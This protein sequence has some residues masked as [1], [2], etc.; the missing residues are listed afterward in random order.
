MFSPPGREALPRSEMADNPP[1]TMLFSLPPQSPPPATPARPSILPV[2]NIESAPADEADE[3]PAVTA[4]ATPVKTSITPPIEAQK[5]KA[6]SEQSEKPRAAPSNT[7]PSLKNMHYHK[8]ELLGEI[9]PR[10]PLTARRQEQ[11]GLIKLKAW[12]KSSG[13]VERVEVLISSGYPVLDMAASKAVK[14]ARF[15]PA[16]MYSN[17]VEG[18]VIISISFQLDQ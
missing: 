8:P 11:E 18:S 3:S 2:E 16:E 1:V 6:F 15:K 12:I 4:S 9:L 5:L 17:T 14:R 10:Y 7:R 13:R